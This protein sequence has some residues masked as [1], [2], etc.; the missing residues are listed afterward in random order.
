MYPFMLGP[1]YFALFFDRYFSLSPWAWFR[2]VSVE[3]TLSWLGW[4]VLVLG[5]FFAWE[6]ANVSSS[7]I[8]PDHANISMSQ[9]LAAARFQENSYFIGGGLLLIALA[10]LGAQLNLLGSYNIRTALLVVFVVFNLHAAILTNY[11]RAGEASELIGQVHT[12]PEFQRIAIR[13]R[14]E[15]HSLAGGHR[16]KVLAENDAVW[17]MSSYMVGLPEYRFGATPEQKKGFDYLMENYDERRTEFTPGF[18]VER[19]GLRGWWVPDYCQV[20][21]KKFLRNVYHYASSLGANR[22]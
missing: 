7:F 20:S 18:F 6:M 10:Y 11:T 5:L 9:P 4:A 1:I 17:P 8:C 22:L 13:I 15:I 21:L 14:D 3:K 19:I 2:T 12:T 16:L